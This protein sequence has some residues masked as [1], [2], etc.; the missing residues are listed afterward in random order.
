V[1]KY[2]RKRRKSRALGAGVPQCLAHQDVYS[3]NIVSGC[4]FEC[5]YC[6]YRARKYTPDDN[7][8]LYAHLPAQ[9]AE[10]IAGL[11]KKGTPPA[12]VLLNTVSESFFGH[13]GVNRTARECLEVLFDHRIYVNLTTK[14]LIPRELYGLLAARSELLTVTCSVASPAESF[15]RLF[16]PRVAPAED[17]LR[18]VRELS[19]V[20]IQVRG[21]VEP[22]IPMENDSLRQVEEL[23]AG[24]RDAG[25]GEVVVSYLQLGPLVAAR[26]RD[27]ISRVQVSL[28][29]PWFHDPN[30]DLNILLD[31]EYRR[32]KYREFKELG[33]GMGL[34]IIICACRNA[35]AYSGRCFVV[36]MELKPRARKALF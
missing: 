28:L 2:H 14:G 15:Q 18:M 9:L 22:L 10:E 8:Y 5:H 33:T 1:I 36:P 12:M 35:D 34:R 30:G 4:P 6:K 3:L 26:L 32:R 19:E 23:F 11:K 24:F 29:A 7:V 16:E 25:V 27:H 17:R 31:P 20:G 21:R 13:E